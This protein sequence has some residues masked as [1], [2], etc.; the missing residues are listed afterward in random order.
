MVRRVVVTGMGFVAAHCRSLD[1]LWNCLHSNSSVARPYE[2]PHHIPLA[3]PADF[4]GHIDDFES[5]DTTQQKA[6]RK[7]LKVMSR[8]IQL[9]IAASCKALNEAKISTM[10]PVGGSFASLLP[11]RVGV[12]IGSDYILT[13]PED[14]LDAVRFCITDTVRPAN[15]P[16]P[17]AQ[18]PFDQ[19]QCDQ[20]CFDHTQW[21]TVGLPKMTPL[22]QLKY[23]PNMPSSHIAILNDFHGPSNSITLREASIGAVIGE[24][25]SIIASGRADVMLVGTTGSRLHPYKLLHAK[26]QEELSPT[27][28]RPF[29]KH[30]DGTILGE[31]AGAL[32]LEEKE[33][34]EARGVKCWAEIGYGTSMAMFNRSGK[35]MRREAVRKSLENILHKADCTPEQV[36]HIDAHGLG[37]KTSD[38]AEALGIHDVFGNRTHPVPVTSAKGCFGNLGAGSGAVE[39]ISG[40]LSLH[41]GTVYPTLNF[42]EADE[43][44]PIFVVNRLDTPSGD[45]FIKIA[46][47]Q[48]AQVSAVLV[49]RPC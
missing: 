47:N 49:R 5:Q 3:V 45:S 16:N 31:G 44:C 34:A 32:V 22:W 33:H 1:Q 12:S 17:V 11:D 39:L 21:G 4:Q 48:Q 27:A 42:S 24:S 28:C 41:Y 25:A 6:I 2:I 9:A 43:S 36:G 20:A 8:E 19:T 14:M 37:S 38:I 26:Q 13:T 29:D 46:M 7:S 18:P 15:A 40:I 35:D 30:R 10:R 23:L